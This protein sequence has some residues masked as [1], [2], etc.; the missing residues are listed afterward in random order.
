M[1]P[2]YIR[3]DGDP[4]AQPRPR[5][6]NRGKHA[7]V[8]SPKTEKK[9]GVT[10]ELPVYTWRKLVAKVARLNR[11]SKPFDGPVRVDLCWLFPRPQRLCRKKDP[12]GRQW[13]IAKPDRDNLDKAI[14]DELK[15]DGWWKDDSQVCVGLLIKCY[16][17]IGESPGLEIRID[18]MPHLSLTHECKA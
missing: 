2:L 9:N 17:A 13:H 1:K 14:L 11:P 3:V 7:G 18:P 12:H 5:A 6:R 4:R 10:V 8:Y 16:H 15:N